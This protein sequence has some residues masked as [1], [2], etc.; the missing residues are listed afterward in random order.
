[1]SLERRRQMIAPQHTRLSVERQ[2]RLVSINPMIGLA[3]RR[4][5]VEGSS[6]LARLTFSG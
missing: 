6:G 5:C 4:S 3:A 2:C 1:M